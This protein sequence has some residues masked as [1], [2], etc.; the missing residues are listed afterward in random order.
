MN[1]TRILEKLIDIRRGEYQKTGL[2]FLYIFLLIASYV[3]IKAVRDSLFLNKF[4]PTQ[5]PY[6][7]I[8]VAAIVGGV[9][10]VHA[11]LSA[12]V[13][14]HVLIRATLLIVV[15]N[16]FIFWWL[17]R[18]GWPSLY[19]VLYI[20]SSAIGILM[21]AQYWLLANSVFNAREAKRLF[22]LIG[23]GAILGG[24]GGGVL[25]ASA[26]TWV[27]AEALL[28]L[29]AVVYLVCG[30]LAS[31]L[32]SYAAPA[33]HRAD[34][35]SGMPTG[36]A[37]PPHSGESILNTLRTSPHLLTIISLIGIGEIVV[38][39][40]DY[41][42]KSI[43]AASFPSKDAL[44]AFMGTFSAGLSASSFVF[45]LLFTG[46][47]LSALGLGLALLFLPAGLLI[48]SVAIAAA[49]GLVSAGMT[50]LSEGS[51][52][53][54]INKAGLEMLYVPLPWTVKARTKPFIDT[55]AERV[56]GG[57]G[58]IILLLSIGVLS[59]SSAQISL[60]SIGLLSIWIPLAVSSRKDYLSSLRL[61]LE[62]RRLDLTSPILN[63]SDPQTV[64]LLTHRLL[65]SDDAGALY[66]LRLLEQADI[67]PYM[68]ALKELLTRRAPEVRGAAV[69]LLTETNDFSLVPALTEMVRDPEIEIRSEAMRFACAHCG[70]P[71]AR[72]GEWLASDDPRVAAAAVL[73]A[74]N[75]PEQGLHELAEQ[76]LNSMIHDHGPQGE[77]R[78]RE[79]AKALRWVHPSPTSSEALMRLLQDE[80]VEVVNAAVKSAAT[81]QRREAVPLLAGLLLRKDTRAEAK[82]AL[83]RYG[84]RILGSLT[85]LLEDPQE[86]IELR[87]TLPQ[88]LAEIREGQVVEI[89]L[90]NLNQS[91]RLLRYR[92]LKALNK[93]RAR[94]PDARLDPELIEARLVTEIRHHYELLL[95]LYSPSI[96]GD[97]QGGQ[98]I[99]KALKERLDHHLEMVF[100]LL[101]LRFPIRDIHDA[102]T[103]LTADD[104]RI[105]AKAAE[106][107]ETLLSSPL[108]QYLIPIIDQWPLDTVVEA[109]KR[110]FSISWSSQE[111]LLSPCRCSKARTS[112][113][114]RR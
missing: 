45:Q 86:P 31:I 53:Y 22:S 69:R 103:G 37:G 62:R 72:L 59:L 98:L 29:S 75:D 43:A 63:L 92:V 76:L 68:P 77:A 96:A 26:V 8:L 23:A 71:R 21:V 33:E 74:L 18:F 32:A 51:F 15:T 52:R 50:K 93:I 66:I 35:S 20:W 91:D 73:C 107:V 82:A 100:R 89:L 105:Q 97:G 58:G 4:G 109:G 3:M 30:G 106:F 39:I 11:K 40:V 110:F 108:K 95:L 56:A 102:Y 67:T 38:T 85:D 1:L 48:G 114:V 9:A 101:G 41:Q 87:R 70:G 47:I 10:W 104:P 79:A 83:I 19:Y 80:A 81:M 54:S 57:I 88:V 2:M 5:L 61:A 28:I 94:D 14:L 112:P 36:E 90:R 111:Q 12:R 113:G 34:P 13:R 44:T 64:E 55:A 99:R 84:S 60:I 42:F 24:I 46:R 16:L 25:T 27:G 78:R 65:N 7:Y 49:P 17:L 6:V